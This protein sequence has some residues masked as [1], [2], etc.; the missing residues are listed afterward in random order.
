MELAE[1]MKPPEKVNVGRL[2]T[3]QLKWPD[4]QDPADSI[5]NRVFTK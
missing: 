3:Q 5:E 4:S 1:R 2:Y